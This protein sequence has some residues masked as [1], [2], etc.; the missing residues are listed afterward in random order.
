MTLAA[1]LSY[2]GLA[3]F[4]LVIT[5]NLGFLLADLY[6]LLAGQETISRRIWS[7]PVLIVAPL[8]WQVVGA[9]CLGVHLLIPPES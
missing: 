4:V 9:L 5:V 8:A 6:L 1:L 2:S 3:G 7:Q